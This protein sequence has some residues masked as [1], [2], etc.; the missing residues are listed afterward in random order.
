MQTVSAMRIDK[1]FKKGYLHF[2][3]VAT[4]EID[5]MARDHSRNNGTAIFQAVPGQ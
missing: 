2:G 3:A 1:S 5:V 4:I